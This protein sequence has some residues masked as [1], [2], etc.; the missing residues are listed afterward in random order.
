VQ[1]NHLSRSG[2]LGLSKASGNSQ[3]TK[4]L[5]SQGQYYTDK[6]FFETAS[7][8]LYL[9]S[10]FRAQKLKRFRTDPCVLPLPS[11]GGGQEAEPDSGEA[12]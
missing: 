10:P 3:K 12:V 2:T 11:A 8:D 4:V 1:E 5:G 7:A 6:M 9:Q